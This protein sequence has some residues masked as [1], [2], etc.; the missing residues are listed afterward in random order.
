MCKETV[1]ASLILVI[2][3]TR[4]SFCSK[5]LLLLT[6]LPSECHCYTSRVYF[7]ILLIV[8]TNFKG[9]GGEY[10]SKGGNPIL[11]IGKANEGGGK[12]SPGPP[13]PPSQINPDRYAD[14]GLYH[15]QR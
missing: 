1:V 6:L 9:R 13:A 7:R 11:S 14:C 4:D 5:T 2:V 12:E 10:E 3:P 8:A 15:I